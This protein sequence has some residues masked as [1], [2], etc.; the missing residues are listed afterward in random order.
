MDGAVTYA[1]CYERVVN[2]DRKVRL[3][4]QVLRFGIPI[5]ALLLV[6]WLF[7]YFTM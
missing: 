2:F 5:V 3:C 1:K 4:G 7:L 6:F